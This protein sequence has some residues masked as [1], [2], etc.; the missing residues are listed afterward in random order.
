MSPVLHVFCTSMQQALPYSKHAKAT[1]GGRVVWEETKNCLSQSWGLWD[2]KGRGCISQLFSPRQELGLGWGERRQ[3]ALVPP[4]WTQFLNLRVNHEI[5]V[6]HPTH[7]WFKA[8][9]CIKGWHRAF[10]FEGGGRSGCW[11]GQDRADTLTCMSQ[12]FYKHT[13]MRMN[14]FK[15]Y[16]EWLPFLKFRRLNLKMLFFQDH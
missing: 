6:V 15:H 10:P 16:M 7:S 11:S 12:A 8:R 9:Y 13:N 2:W 5:R 14:S 1:E 4:S 3:C